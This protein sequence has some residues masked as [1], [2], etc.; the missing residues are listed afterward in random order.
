[1]SQKTITVIGT[2]D[3][4][5]AV[6][7][8]L[9][10]GGHRVVTNL[11]GRSA[12][13]VELSHAS[14]LEDLGSLEA[15]IAEADLVLS[16]LPPAQAPGFARQAAD[17]IRATGVTPLFADCNAVSP[18]TVVELGTVVSSAGA[19]FLDVGIV[20]PA[21]RKESAP[22]RFYASGE[23]VGDLVELGVPEIRVIDMGSEIGRAS[24]LKA[25]Y[26]GLNKGTQALQTTV[27]LAAE[28]LGVRSELMEELQGSQPQAVARMQ[29]QVPHLA[30]TA[31]RFAG[32][33]LEI[34]STYESVGV[35]GKMH[36]GAAWLF[37]LLARTPLAAETRATLDR[38][39]SLDEAVE[40]FSRSLDSPL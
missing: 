23:R 32:E 1:M 33:M 9:V 25:T 5:S 38:G 15:A 8:V 37:E 10:D 26:A 21:P 11:S 36:E 40:V 31:E 24:A 12:H 7:R 19:V 27:L 6:G 18:Q 34:A 28:R 4:G 22:T 16:I 20:G 39:R 13:S 29:Q 30:A 14:G 35:T 17:A 3:M 2:G